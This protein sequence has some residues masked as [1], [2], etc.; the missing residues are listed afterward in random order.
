MLSYYDSV[1]LSGIERWIWSIWDGKKRSIIVPDKM[2]EF[3]ENLTFTI[4]E[5]IHLKLSQH[6]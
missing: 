3:N 2:S 1:G 4:S 6:C 5:L